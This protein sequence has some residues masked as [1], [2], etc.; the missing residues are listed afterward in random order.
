[1]PF[2]TQQIKYY[3][4]RDSSELSEMIYIFGV[5]RHLAAVVLR[6]SNFR[7]V[8]SYRKSYSVISDINKRCVCC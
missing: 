1:M 5:T 7:C 3:Q 6:Y 2:T 8:A 4:I